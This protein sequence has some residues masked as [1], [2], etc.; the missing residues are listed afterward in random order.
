VQRRVMMMACIVLSI[1]AIADAQQ[2]QAAPPPEAN[3]PPVFF[4]EEWKHQFD[5]GGP[6]EGPLQSQHVSNPN[7]ELRIYGE[8]PKGDKSRTQRAAQSRRHVDEQEVQRRPGAHFHGD[9]QQAMR[10]YVEA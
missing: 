2:R 8:T 7:L 3:R 10:A 5:V 9:V 4:R 1:G 6:P